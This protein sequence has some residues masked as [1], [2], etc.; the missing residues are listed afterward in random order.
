MQNSLYHIFNTNSSSLF[1]VYLVVNSIHVVYL[2][3]SSEGEI[4]PL[5]TYLLT[6]FTEANV[7]VT[8]Q[9]TKMNRLPFKSLKVPAGSDLNISRDELIKSQNDDVTLVRAFEQARDGKVTKYERG[10][11]SSYKLISGLLYRV[12]TN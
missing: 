9:Q 3:R 5:L 7:V 11:E 1:N 10:G 12:Y 6:Y 2:L 8:R 4:K